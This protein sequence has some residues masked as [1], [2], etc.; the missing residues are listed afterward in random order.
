MSPLNPLIAPIVQKLDGMK[1]GQ[2]ILLKAKTSAQLN[3]TR[4]LLYVFFKDQNLKHSF[5]IRREPN[6]QLRIVCKETEALTLVQDI[7]FNAIECFVQDYLLD[8]PTE[9]EAQATVVA[10]AEQGLCADAD[11]VPILDEW[12]RLQGDNEGDH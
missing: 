5:S 11:V 3:R 12:R 9:G 6:L 4:N 10:A 8:C 1:P 2:S 7:P